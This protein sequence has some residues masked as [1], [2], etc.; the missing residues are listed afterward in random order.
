MLLYTVSPMVTL[1]NLFFFTD[2][3]YLVYILNDN[4]KI[5]ELN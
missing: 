4:L 3:H 2:V 1:G 5:L